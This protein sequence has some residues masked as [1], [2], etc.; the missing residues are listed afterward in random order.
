MATFSGRGIEVNEA[1]IK[2][3]VEVLSETKGIVLAAYKELTEAN[4]VFANNLM[5]NNKI[6]F[7]VAKENIEKY[8]LNTNRTL[9]K[10]SHTLSDYADKNSVINDEAALHAG[11]ETVEQVQM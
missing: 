8:I 10:L 2:V 3:G 11:G 9:G 7:A 6:T 1:N 4:E 5:G